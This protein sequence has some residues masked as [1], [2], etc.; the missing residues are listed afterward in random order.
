MRSKRFLSHLI[1]TLSR[2]RK[3][4]TRS[5]WEKV[6]IV[7]KSLVSRR[8]HHHSSYS[9]DREKH[10]TLLTLKRRKNVVH[11]VTNVEQHELFGLDAGRPLADVI[12]K[13]TDSLAVVEGVLSRFFQATAAASAIGHVCQARLV[14]QAGKGVTH[15]AQVARWAR[16][17]SCSRSS[18]LAPNS[19]ESESPPSSSR[20]ARWEDQKRNP[21]LAP[22]IVLFEA[23]KGHWT[24]EGYEGPF[25]TR[26]QTVFRPKAYVDLQPLGLTLSEEKSDS[27]SVSTLQSPSR[28]C[29]SMQVFQQASGSPDQ[30]YLDPRCAY[31]G[32]RPAYG[33]K[34][35]S[36]LYFL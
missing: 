10:H 36:R 8:P 11:D 30:A 28:L 16:T 31:V 13:R 27:P 4:K 35:W 23:V 24:Q 34:A 14:V 3:H 29:P 18:I 20:A 33:P 2:C 7:I 15:F 9:Q 22:D 21:P 6:C 32:Y 26:G 5:R 17:R 25:G 1:L 19:N 12:T